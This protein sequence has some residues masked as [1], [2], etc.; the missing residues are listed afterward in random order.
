MMEE[1]IIELICSQVHSIKNPK[2]SNDIYVFAHIDELSETFIQFLKFPCSE[3]SIERIGNKVLEALSIFA[4][5]SLDTHK[6]QGALDDLAT[7]F[8]SY[9]KKIAVLRY[10]GDTIRLN[11]DGINYHGLLHTPLGSILEGKVAK[12]NPKDNLVA[13]DTIPKVV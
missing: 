2:N 8:E 10:E 4:A 1:K 11:G 9:L 5:L 13:P 6:L 7:G 12:V 3:P